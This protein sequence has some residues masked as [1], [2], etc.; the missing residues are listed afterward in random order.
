MLIPLMGQS[1]SML[2]KEVVAWLK[3]GA[4]CAGLAGSGSM[5][6][7]AAADAERGGQGGAAAGTGA[8]SQGRRAP[9][10]AA[11]A[12]AEAP[13][14]SNQLQ[15]VQ[16]DVTHAA[17]CLQQIWCPGGTCSMLSN[18]QGL[19]Q[20]AC[21]IRQRSPHSMCAASPKPSCWD[22]SRA[23]NPVR[24]Q[25]RHAKLIMGCAQLHSQS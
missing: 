5:Q 18:L 17:L 2:N 21:L 20:G 3:R 4:A 11:G 9:Q 14:S 10:A 12:A 15:K 1:A 7:R 23:F 16:G 13:G 25:S 19:H 22:V 6:E 24:A 8:G